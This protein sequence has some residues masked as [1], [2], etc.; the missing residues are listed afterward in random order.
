MFRGIGFSRCIMTDLFCTFNRPLCPQIIPHT[1]G[2]KSLETKAS[3]K[4]EKDTTLDSAG[5][6]EQTSWYFVCYPRSA[7]LM[8]SSQTRRNLEQY[9][10]SD[11]KRFLI[12][13]LHYL[14]ILSAIKL[15]LSISRW[16]S[17][18]LN[19]SFQNISLF[20]ILVNIHFASTVAFSLIS[21]P[22]LIIF[23]ANLYD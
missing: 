23:L 14:P 11:I 21:S 8:L 19:G 10:I 17:G 15:S 7:Q 2:A 5:V 3:K 1:R 22:F 6:T 18:T 4:E 9:L 13:S 16:V 20:Y 12:A